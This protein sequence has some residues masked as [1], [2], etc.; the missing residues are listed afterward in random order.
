MKRAFVFLAAGFEEVEAI[1]PIDILRRAGVDVVVVGVSGR[2]V[3]SAR[4]LR[5]ACDVELAAVLKGPPPDLLVFPGGAGAGVLA[6]SAELR[7]FAERAADSGS[8]LG[9]ICAAPA[10]VLGSW[11]LIRGRRCTGF[12][13]SSDGMALKLSG[14]RVVVDG[15]L[16]TALA[17]GTAEEFALALVGA[18]LGRE[19]AEKLR[20]QLHAR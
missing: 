12:P 6:A 4:R 2:E 8:I 3:E 13:G 14:E 15:K 19:A 5:V 17:A 1:A 11:G 20:A 7:S 16:V 18:L 9:A 10:V